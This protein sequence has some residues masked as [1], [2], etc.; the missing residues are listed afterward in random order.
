VNNRKGKDTLDRIPVRHVARGIGY[1]DYQ[2]ELSRCHFNITHTL[3]ETFCQAALESLAFGQWLIAPKKLTFPELVPRGY[4]FLYENE[5]KPS[6][7]RAHILANGWWHPDHPERKK[8]QNHTRDTYNIRAYA[9]HYIALIEAMNA[10]SYADSLKPQ[11]LAKIAK[12]HT[13]ALKTGR[14]RIPLHRDAPRDGTRALGHQAMNPIKFKRIL[15]QIGWRDDPDAAGCG[16]WLRARM[17][18]MSAR[19]CARSRY[20]TTRCD[21]HMS[22]NS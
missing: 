12:L 18:P 20:D 13:V 15:N 9:E 1:E 8:L 19:V 3:H 22:R 6:N 2:T 21:A 7:S 17:S 11:S 14:S 16:C 4:P 5:D 10:W